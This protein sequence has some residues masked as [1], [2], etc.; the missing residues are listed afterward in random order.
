M[1]KMNKAKKMLKTL[2]LAI[3]ATAIFVGCENAE[4]AEAAERAQVDLILAGDVAVA[5]VPPVL[6][7]FTVGQNEQETPEFMSFAGTVVEI[8]P[9]VVIEPAQSDENGV[10]AVA[11]Y[12]TAQNPLESFTSEDS[13]VVVLLENELGDLVNFVVNESSLVIAENAIVPGTTLIG[14]YDTNL[15]IPLIFPPR[16]T[17]KVLFAPETADGTMQ[18]IYVSRFN[19]SETANTFVS[20]DGSTQISLSNVDISFADGLPFEGDFDELANRAFAVVHTG[21]TND[22]YPQGLSPLKI[23]VLFERAVHPIHYFTEEELALLDLEIAESVINGGNIITDSGT[24]NNLG[25]GAFQLSEDDLNMF[26]DSMFDPATVQIIVNDVVID[27]PIPVVNREVGMVM[28]PVA[29]VAAE[30]GYTVTGTGADVVIS[31]GEGAMLEL[32]RDIT[33]TVGEDSYFIGDAPIQLFAAPEMHGGTLFVPISF[34]HDILPHA[35]Y[36]ADGNV[37]V[38]CFLCG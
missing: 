1:K 29:A 8:L 7:D 37:I 36:I 11:T 4:A 18:D 17:A 16:Y 23:Y 19:E 21:F 14:V 32:F 30:L 26:W 33:F 22:S 3:A 28:L 5:N 10:L 12:E 31:S 9:F 2:G 34:F 27:S 6:T 24:D 13:N 20:W 15:M 35:A 25:G 38:F